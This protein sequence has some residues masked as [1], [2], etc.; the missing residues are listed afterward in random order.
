MIIKIDIDYYDDP[1]G[2]KCVYKLPNDSGRLRLLRKT[3]EDYLFDVA[4][5]NGIS[6][7]EIEDKYGHIVDMAY[8][9]KV[10][11]AV[12]KEILNQCNVLISQYD[13]K[14]YL[15]KN[16]VRGFISGYPN[17]AHLVSEYNI[18]MYLDYVQTMREYK[19]HNISN[20]KRDGWEW[21]KAMTAKFPKK[22]IEHRLNI[23]K[24]MLE[25][26]KVQIEMY[27]D[28]ELF[29]TYNVFLRKPVAEY[30]PTYGGYYNANGW[31]KIQYD[32]QCN[33]TDVI[34]VPVSDYYV[35]K[36]T[37]GKVTI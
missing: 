19:T 12:Q 17:Q 5:K 8:S 14:R 26:G 15:P 6:C 23:E 31:V 21:S 24:R 27:K 35:R 36:Y 18:V 25:L 9:K 16:L 20:R 34:Q 3:R 30:L 32:D 22:L 37:I 33:E 28:G 7:Q 10:D 29:Q 11:E 1:N 13:T 2:D 4:K